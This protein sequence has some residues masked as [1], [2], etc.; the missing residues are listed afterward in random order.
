MGINA[1]WI[2][3][4]RLQRNPESDWG[5]S[6]IAQAGLFQVF[7]WIFW[8][9]ILVKRRRQMTLMRCGKQRS[10]QTTC[11]TEPSLWWPD[12]ALLR[13]NAEPFWLL[14]QGEVP[15]AVTCPEILLRCIIINCYFVCS[16]TPC[17]SGLPG[18]LVG[19]LISSSLSILH[20]YYTCHVSWGLLH[21]LSYYYL[22]MQ[23]Y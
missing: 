18:C 3:I 16:P 11:V 7:V 21:L 13:W 14:K 6:V 20:P 19:Q 22:L 8:G 2:P 4:L 15:A 23:K 5:T 17:S 1:G 9:K 10:P 12:L